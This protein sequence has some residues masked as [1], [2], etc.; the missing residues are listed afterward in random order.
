QERENPELIDGSR[1]KRIASGSG[2]SITEVNKLMKQ[3]DEMRKMMKSFNK[4][5]PGRRM[6]NMPNMGRR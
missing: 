3:F 5:K 4:M 2:N 6:P 1:R